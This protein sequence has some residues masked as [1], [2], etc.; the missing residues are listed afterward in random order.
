MTFVLLDCS[1]KIDLILKL[2]DNFRQQG[3][4]ENGRPKVPSLCKLFGIIFQTKKEKGMV[5]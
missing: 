3:Q 5:Q 2:G 4:E 1:S